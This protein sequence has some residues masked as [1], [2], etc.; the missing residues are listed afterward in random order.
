LSFY[1]QRRHGSPKGVATREL[2]VGDDTAA[3]A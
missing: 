1:Q 2:A 3:S